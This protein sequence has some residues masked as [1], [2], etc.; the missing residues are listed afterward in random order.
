M[1]S[2]GTKKGRGL[3]TA[4][5]GEPIRKRKKFSFI[6]ATVNIVI[7]PTIM[8]EKPSTDPLP[9]CPKGHRLAA[10]G[11]ECSVCGAS[12]EDPAAKLEEPGGTANPSMA[13]NNEDDPVVVLLRAIQ[14]GN[15]KAEV[16]FAFT[17][18]ILLVDSEIKRLA[19]YYIKG[20]RYIATFQTADLAQEYYIQLQ[21]LAQDPKTIWVSREQ[22]LVMAA[23]IM[24]HI[25]VDHARKRNAG[26]RGG[27]A[28][29]ISL[30][31]AF[32]YTDDEAWQV[33]AVHAALEKLKTLDERQY[34]IVELRVFGGLEVDETAEILKISTTTVKREFR[35]A[36]AWLR[37]ELSAKLSTQSSTMD[38]GD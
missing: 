10:V 7:Q 24:R 19:R 6:G 37:R 5:T 23:R 21:R 15:S 26:K 17:Q 14:K 20:E 35:V 8:T 38:D 16:Q 11:A 4:V 18:L 27:P 9:N 32:A 13:P 3:G 31:N 34:Y 29:T 33:V 25:L 22:F 12:L 36:K 30:E 2:V 28:L 1:R